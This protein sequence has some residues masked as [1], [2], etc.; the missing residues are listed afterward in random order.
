MTQEY[1]EALASGNE[2][3]ANELQNAISE[4]KK[5]LQKVA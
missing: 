3:K 4:K 2:E 1:S 5:T